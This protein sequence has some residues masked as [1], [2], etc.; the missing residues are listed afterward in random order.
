MKKT[1]K[2]YTN[3]ELEFIYFK[4]KTLMVLSFAGG[5]LTAAAIYLTLN[6]LARG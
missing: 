6:V 3:S 4:A 1:V 2:S 5:M